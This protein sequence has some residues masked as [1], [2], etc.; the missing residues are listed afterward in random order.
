MSCCH[1]GVLGRRISFGRL[2][3]D[4]PPSTWLPSAWLS[5]VACCCAL[6]V[7]AVTPK[8]VHRDVGLPSLE[9]HSV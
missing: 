3:E 4:L 1:Q 6:L 8:L 9:V 2:R 5:S 7:S